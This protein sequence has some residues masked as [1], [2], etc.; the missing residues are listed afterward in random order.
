MGGEKNEFYIKE[1]VTLAWTGLIW[2]RT[3]AG[4]GLLYVKATMDIRVP[5]NSRNFLTS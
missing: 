5:H 3:G 2:L 4:G 1:M